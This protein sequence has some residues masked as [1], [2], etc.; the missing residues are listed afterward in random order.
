MGTIGGVNLAQEI[1]KSEKSEISGRGGAILLQPRVH[2]G[3]FDVKQI[4]SHAKQE[5]KEW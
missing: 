1:S 2:V 3:C 5:S 4:E